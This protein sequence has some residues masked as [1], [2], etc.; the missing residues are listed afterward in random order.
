MRWLHG[1]GKLGGGEQEAAVAGDREHRHIA[2]RILCAQR[3]GKTPAQR[4]LIAGRQKR[5]RLVD[6]KDQPRGEAELGDLV[7]ENAVL[8]QFGAHHFEEG[9]L[10]GDLLEALAPLRLA[11][12]HF[13]L[14]RCALGVARR[15]FREQALQDRLGVAD[16]RHPGP[17]P[18]IVF[19]RIG[20]DADDGEVAIDAP[21]AKL[22]EQPGA[23]R[24][25]RVGLAPQFVPQRQ[26]DAE[27]AAA[28]ENAAAAPIGQHRRLQHGGQRRDFRRGV[29]GA[30]AADDHRPLGG[31][32]NRRRLA[33]GVAVDV[34]RRQRQ[35]RLHD[36]RAAL[37][38]DVDGAFEDR[39]SG[40]AAVHSAQRQRRL[41]R[42]L[43]GLADQRR[44]V[45]QPLDNAML[46]ADLMQMAE[47]APDIGLKNL[48]DQT[49]HGRVHRVGSQQRGRGIEQPRTRDHGIGLRLAGRQRRAER[50]QRGTLLMPG[51]HRPQPVRS[52]EQRLE[53]VVVLHPGQG[54]DRVQPMR[55]QGRD[56]GVGRGHDFGI[57]G[58]PGR[59]AFLRH[60]PLP[61]CREVADR[62]RPVEARVPA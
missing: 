11:L 13:R 2:P 54:V 12:V 39:G 35:R 24:E 45:D 25:H 17:L 9:D 37:A 55:D 26:G 53:Q 14:P 4:I 1:G 7:D 22:H 47:A 23:D 59:L 30:A 51:M 28:I 5:A 46:V 18:A 56:H 61:G 58:R 19:L 50:H 48:P 8:R 6:G 43:F 49:E 31:A 21:F 32:E 10:R 27:R 34:R 33:H 36:D 44:V 52:L 60:F 41:S 42:R 29:L 38:P 3:R 15:Q 40:P 16:E 57:C 20:I 62:R